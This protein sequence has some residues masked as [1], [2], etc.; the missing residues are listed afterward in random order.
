MDRSRV[1]ADR[2]RGRVTHTKRSWNTSLLVSC[3]DVLLRAKRRAAC[4]LDDGRPRFTC[5]SDVATRLR[6]EA[7]ASP[8]LAK[9]PV[10]YMDSAGDLRCAHHL[11]EPQLLLGQGRV[12]LPPE[13]LRVI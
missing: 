1:R 11:K 6:A 8:N 10:T 12:T 5:G 13:F 9:I 2:V 3:M 4:S 7:T